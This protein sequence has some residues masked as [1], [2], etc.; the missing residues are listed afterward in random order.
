MGSAKR[1]MCAA[2]AV[3]LIFGTW[4]VVAQ[5]AP[6]KWVTG[7]YAPVPEPS[8]EYTNAVSNGKLYLIG[9]NSAVLTPGGRNMHPARVL[10][11]DLAADKWTQKKQVPFF[12]DHMTAAA[13]NGKIYVFGGSGAMTQEAPSATLDTAW[14]YDPAADSWKQLARLTAKRTAGAAAEVGGK[15]YFIGGSSDLTGPDGKV[16]NAGLVVGSNESFD[17][18]TNKWETHKAMPT[19]RNHPAIGVVAGKIY[20]IGGRITANNI[21]GFTAANVDVVEEYSPATDSW[22]AMNRMPTPRSGEGWT[23]YQGKIYVAGGEHRDYHIEGVLRDVEVFDPAVNDW[24]RLP[25]MPTARHGVN[26]AA[27]NGKL[28]VIGGHLVFAGG[29]GHALDAPTNE[30]FEFAA[31]AAGRTN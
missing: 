2:V 1:R 14:E 31:P 27:F 7:K 4:T 26:V 15:I 28:F 12:A 19:P 21:G 18:A 8:E 20:V 25:A 22:R 10:E 6:G 29:G 13:F 23:T 3:T 16:A 11:Y 24:Y 5:Q 9:G 17:P 30:V